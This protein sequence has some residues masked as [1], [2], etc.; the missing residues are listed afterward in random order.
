MKTMRTTNSHATLLVATVLLLSLAVPGCGNGA[1]AAASNE[2]ASGAAKLDQPKARGS[3]AI[4][5]NIG[6]SLKHDSIEIDIDALVAG[7]RDAS[8]T[9][10]TQLTDAEMAEAMSTIQS[11]AAEI[12]RGKMSVA[13]TQNREE[14]QKYLAANAAKEGV[15]TT[16]SGLQ[17]R[18]VRQGDGAKPTAT[19]QVKVHYRGTTIGGATF[20]A[21]YDRGEPVVFPV[22]QVIAGW[23]EALQL[24]T[25]GSEWQLVIPA[26]LAYGLQPPPGAKFGP[27]SVLL[28]DVELLEIVK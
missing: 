8:E 7:L 17:Y 21:S 27:D 13:S 26:N 15:V 10:T 22:N 11:Q 23:T 6:R 20:D 2:G 5:V 1:T 3:Y 12:K 28:F 24:M 25:V 14:G 16:T 4:G 19:S 18:V 9:E